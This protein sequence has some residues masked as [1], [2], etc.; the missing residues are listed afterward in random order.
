LD[1]GTGVVELEND[2]RA[3]NWIVVAMQDFSA[4]NLTSLALRRFLD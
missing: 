3:A 4:N 2:I 1:A